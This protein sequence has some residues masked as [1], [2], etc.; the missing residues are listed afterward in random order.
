M[1]SYLDCFPCFCKQTLEAVRYVTDDPAVHERALRGVLK[2]ASEMKLQSTP[3]EMG[4]YIHNLVRKLSGN[5]DPYEK[6]K[7]E[8]NAAA[9]ALYPKLKEAVRE[10]KDPLETAV[11]LA[12]AGNIID[13]GA[14]PGLQQA[15][16]WK[17]VDEALTQ[18]LPGCGIP[19]FRAA[20]ER[21][22]RILYLGDNA[23]EIVFDRLLVEELGTEKTIF[24]VRGRP[25]VNDA[26][27]ADAAAVGMTEV[28][29][30]ITNG[31][32]VPGT[33]LEE[34]SPEFRDEF[35]RA[36]LVISKGQGNYETL[37]EVPQRIF[38]LLMI[39]CEIIARDIGFQPGSMVLARRGTRTA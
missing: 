30:V 35:D 39:K 34:C 11:R 25:I 2:A 24:A 21:A 4:R 8:Y 13:F 3:P 5:A 9:L 33:L 7:A 15:S 32:D 18:P 22:E 17:V 36:D 37:S 23:G 10:A 6:V 38:F 29:R 1:K 20:V 12:I 26:T 27:M 16:V 19:A 31:S 28:V 14:T